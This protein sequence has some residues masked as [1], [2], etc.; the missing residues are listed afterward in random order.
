MQMEL[1]LFSFSHKSA[2]N[3]YHFLPQQGSQQNGI[4]YVLTLALVHQ[5][6]ISLYL[7]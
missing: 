7:L 2:I 6:V 3:L 5:L 1:V 4:L